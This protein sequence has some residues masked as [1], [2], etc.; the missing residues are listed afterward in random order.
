MKDGA[1]K[2]SLPSITA[3]ASAPEKARFR[4]LAERAGMSESALALV[5]I[6]K[7]L[8]DVPYAGSNT[9]SERVAATDRITIR[10]RPGDGSAIARRAAERGMKASGYL[11]ALARAHLRMKPALPSAELRG[12]KDAVDVLAG[13]SRVLA[14]RNAAPTVP[15]REA[16]RRDLEYTRAAVAALEQRMHDLAKAA[17]ISWEARYE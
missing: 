15:E 8:E 11:A 7:L 13:L 2:A 6:R 17:L 3:R 4:W 1:S 12:L 9:Q 14:A 16:L 10:L 5:A